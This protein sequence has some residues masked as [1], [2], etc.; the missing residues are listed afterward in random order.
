[1]TQ[2]GNIKLA[3]NEFATD[4]TGGSSVTQLSTIQNN[5]NRDVGVSAVQGRAPDGSVYRG[6]LIKRVYGNGD[7]RFYLK[8]NGPSHPLPPTIKSTEEAKIYAR[9]QISKGVWSDFPLGDQ[10]AFNQKSSPPAKSPTISNIPNLPAFDK[11]M[12]PVQGIAPDGT[13]LTGDLIQ[14]VYST[15]YVRFYFKGQND[16]HK[17]PPSIVSVEQ[18][19]EYSRKKISSGE[20]TDFNRGDQAAF[21]KKNTR[22]AELRRLPAYL[23]V[24]FGSTTPKLTVAGAVIVGREQ[25]HAVR[26]AG[27]RGYFPDPKNERYINF[28]NDASGGKALAEVNF[29][30]VSYD[31]RCK[32]ENNCAIVGGHWGQYDNKGLVIPEGASPEFIKSYQETARLYGQKF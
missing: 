1:M 17:L 18:A 14:R 28:P 29:S 24:D 30:N 26:K 9:Q 8:G 20:W 7:L 23:A 16:S 12:G 31:D 25:A 5:P 19:R 4:V 2:V 11:G 32:K 15:G 13:V 22:N 3:S 21:D 27:Y 6:Q 10:T